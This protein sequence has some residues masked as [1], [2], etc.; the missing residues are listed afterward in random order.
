MHVI[1]R[2]YL[3]HSGWRRILRRRL[4]MARRQDDVFCGELSLVAVDAIRNPLDCIHDG[5]TLRLLDRGYQMLQ[6]MPDGAPWAVTA[7][8]DG[9]GQAAEWYFDVTASSGVEFGL[10]YYDDLLLDVVV[11][12]DGTVHLLDEDELREAVQGGFVTP[13]QEAFAYGV[14]RDIREGIGSDVRALRSVTDEHLAWMGENGRER[15]LSHER[16]TALGRRFAEMRPYA[17]EACAWRYEGPYHVYNLSSDTLPELIAGRYCAYIGAFNEL[18]GF[19]CFAEPAR[20]PTA[21]AFDWEDGKIDIGVGLRPDLCGKGGGCV[22]F[23]DVLRW[24]GGRFPG[25]MFR[26]SVAAWNERAMRVYRRCGFA[27]VRNV[28]HAASGEAF[29]VMER[30]VPS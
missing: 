8:L 16:P 10:P 13:G 14:A 3:D 24:M 1:R 19:A 20:I 27:P 5:R 30:G 25:A 28:T 2:K 23:E 12:Q 7:F 15:D 26:L 4:W 29:V 6:W 17:R 18:L 9:E 21:E 11:L 22:F